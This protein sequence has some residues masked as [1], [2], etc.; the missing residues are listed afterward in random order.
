MKLGTGTIK[1]I[2]QFGSTI[3]H[4]MSRDTV[5]EL[6]LQEEI[7]SGSHPSRGFPA[8]HTPARKARKQSANN[9]GDS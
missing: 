8:T 7:Q 6:Q 1:D 5:D 4:L 2:W 3:A 9:L